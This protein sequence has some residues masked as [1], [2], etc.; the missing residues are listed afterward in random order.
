MA[1]I[2]LLP[3]QVRNEPF[4][5]FGQ[6]RRQRRIIRRLDEQDGYIDRLLLKP[7]LND[8]QLPRPAPLPPTRDS[9]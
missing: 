7:A 1:S 5:T 4:H 2:Y 8:I 6:T 9:Q 3:R